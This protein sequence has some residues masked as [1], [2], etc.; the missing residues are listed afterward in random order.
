M[1]VNQLNAGTYD[2]NV[3]F[4]LTLNLLDE[5]LLSERSLDLLELF[6]LIFY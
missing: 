1:S 4:S 2:I 3:E 5:T 6:Q